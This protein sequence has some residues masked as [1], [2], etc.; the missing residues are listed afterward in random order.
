M[1]YSSDSF[2]IFYNYRCKRDLMFWKLKN[3]VKYLK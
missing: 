3:L 1:I 2:L